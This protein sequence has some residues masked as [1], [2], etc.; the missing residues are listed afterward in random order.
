MDHIYT[1]LGLHYKA[2]GPEHPAD[3]PPAGAAHQSIGFGFNVF[4]FKLRVRDR[5]DFSLLLNQPTTWA[6][7]G[8]LFS[9][10]DA[11]NWD[12]YE[13]YNQPATNSEASMVRDLEALIDR[14]EALERTW[15]PPPTARRAWP[16][17]EAL[18]DRL[19]AL[20]RTMSVW[21]DDFE[22]RMNAFVSI[23]SL[24]NV[25]DKVTEVDTK[26]HNLDLKMGEFSDGSDSHQSD[27]HQSDSH[28]SDS[29]QAAS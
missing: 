25:D 27:S 14:L 4:Q 16:D 11:V 9:P 24:N 7:K 18:T 3:A 5:P 20:E 19:G 15:G 1:L 2:A 26:V 29:P 8:I 12:L 6:N 10:S 28:Q 23:T 13:A 17:L 21:F 22:R